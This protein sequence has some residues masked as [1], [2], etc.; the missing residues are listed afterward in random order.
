MLSLQ[1]IKNLPYPRRKAF[2]ADRIVPMRNASLIWTVAP[3][4]LVILSCSDSSVSRSVDPAPNSNFE[5]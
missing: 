1:I 4:I 5:I 3:L 2:R